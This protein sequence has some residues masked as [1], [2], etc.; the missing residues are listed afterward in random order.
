VEVEVEVEVEVVVG[1]WM[2]KEGRLKKL[3]VQ[4]SNEKDRIHQGNSGLNSHSI[5]AWLATLAPLHFSWHLKRCNEIMT[6]MMRRQ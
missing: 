2:K 5:E 6:T 1:G 4:R 3:Q